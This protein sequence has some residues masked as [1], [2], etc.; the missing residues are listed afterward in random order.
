[1][2]A[3][4]RPRADLLLTLTQRFDPTLTD[5]GDPLL[6]ATPIEELLVP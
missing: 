2:I 6:P 3:M 1:M 5:F 4:N